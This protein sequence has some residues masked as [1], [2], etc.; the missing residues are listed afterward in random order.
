MITYLYKHYFQKNSPGDFHGL[1]VRKIVEVMYDKTVQAAGFNALLFNGQVLSANLDPGMKMKDILDN[2]ESSRYWIR[3]LAQLVRV[4][5]K[6]ILLS[7]RFVASSSTEGRLA[8]K[9]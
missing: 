9:I 5:N 4:E 7:G 3:V 1:G 8:S 2:G 6:K